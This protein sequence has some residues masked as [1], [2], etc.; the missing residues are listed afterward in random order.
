LIASHDVLTDE[1]RETAALY[2]LGLL[3]GPDAQGF[4]KHLQNCRICREE[5]YAQ[6]E[7]TAKI[8]LSAPLVSPPASLREKVLSG[9]P[10]PYVVAKAGDGGWVPF[11][12]TG[13][14]MKMLGKD[15]TTGT[16]SFLLRLQPGA[17][18]PPH[19]H[20][21]AEHCYVIEGDLYDHEHSLTAGDFELRRAGSAHAEV[22]T[23]TGAVVL[24]VA[25]G[26]D[27]H[28]Q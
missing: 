4:A 22:S 11:G 13:I 10:Q 20:K 25:S 26:H 2:A 23:R 5:A 1:I 9:L 18:L 16:R 24:I 19:D 14:D 7:V 12:V 15:S 3:E 17:V 21:G 6:A 27:E 8:S 28:P